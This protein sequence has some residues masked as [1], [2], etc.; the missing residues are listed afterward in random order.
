MEDSPYENILTGLGFSFGLALVLRLFKCATRLQIDASCGKVV[1][2]EPRKMLFKGWNEV[3]C[4]GV[5]HLGMGEQ[6]GD[7][8]S[9]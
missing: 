9:S 1:Y 7:D 2:A 6:D 8:Q 4:S 5:Q 3:E